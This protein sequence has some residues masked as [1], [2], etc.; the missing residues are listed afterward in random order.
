MTV[1]G[2]PQGFTYYRDAPTIPGG[3]ALGGAGASTA[4]SAQALSVETPTV[5]SRELRNQLETQ[6]R[7]D[8]MKEERMQLTVPRRMPMY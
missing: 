6:R 1:V 4:R 3:A 2:A 7:I 8:A 5:Q